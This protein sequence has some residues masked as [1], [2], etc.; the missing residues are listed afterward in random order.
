MTRAGIL[1]L[2]LIQGCQWGEKP[3]DR[4]RRDVARPL[5][6]LTKDEIA[7]VDGI[8]I[9][10]TAFERVRSSLKGAPVETV[11]WVTI[12]AAVLKADA[13]R[14]ARKL[15]IQEAVGIARY[16]SGYP[17]GAPVMNAARAYFTEISENNAPEPPAPRVVKERL[18][19]LIQAADIKKNAPILSNLK[20]K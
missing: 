4:V 10:L 18:E 11:Y 1:V 12:A 19:R 2:L 16:A 14:S 17:E 5:P 9:S 8:P 20:Y 13:D 15:T 3:E 6:R 7:V